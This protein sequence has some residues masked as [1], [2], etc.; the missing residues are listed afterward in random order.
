MRGE[1]LSSVGAQDMDT[2]ENPVFDLDDVEVYW[3]NEQLDVDAVLRSGVD[4]PFL[5]TAFDD[6]EMGGSS[7][8]T[9]LLDEKEDKENSNLPTTPVSERPTW[10]PEWL[11]SR[12]F[13]RRIEN[14]PDYVYRIFFSISFTLY[15]F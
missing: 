9:V 3:E 5:P 6:L 12:P 13:G 8:N 11:R 4:A 1:V 15:M 10:P 7:G 2:S 14:A